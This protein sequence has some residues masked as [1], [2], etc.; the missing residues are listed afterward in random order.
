MLNRWRSLPMG[1]PPWVLVV[2]AVPELLM[3][4]VMDV[5]PSTVIRCRET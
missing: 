1:R 4:T 3:F 2:G 5:V